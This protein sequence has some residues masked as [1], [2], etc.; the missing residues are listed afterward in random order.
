MLLVRR[1]KRSCLRAKT[2]WSPIGQE[3]ALECNAYYTLLSSTMVWSSH[4]SYCKLLCSL[5]SGNA[6]HSFRRVGLWTNPTG[7]TFR[8]V[9]IKCQP[10]LLPWAHVVLSALRTNQLL[11]LTLLLC[12]SWIQSMHCNGIY[13]TMQCYNMSS[14]PMLERKGQL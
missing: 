14:I 10:L 9:P 1:W 3:Q 13:N 8:A 2:I 6:I 4:I 12:I 11:W 5:R 7:G